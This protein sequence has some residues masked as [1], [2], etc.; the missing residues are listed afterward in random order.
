MFDRSL[1]KRLRSRPY[2]TDAAGNVTQTLNG[3]FIL[4]SDE[5]IEMLAST[6]A[7]TVTEKQQLRGM[8]YRVTAEQAGVWHV[9]VWAGQ[10]SAVCL[11]IPASVWDNPDGEPPAKVKKFF[12]QLWQEAV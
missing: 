1:A 5:L 2:Q 7:L 10:E 8:A 9:P 11:R 3:V 12:Q 6:D 4:L